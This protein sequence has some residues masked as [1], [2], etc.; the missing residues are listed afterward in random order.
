MFHCVILQ[1]IQNK[2][3]SSSPRAVAVNFAFAHD[4]CQYC[5]HLSQR[6]ASES[7]E[8]SACRSKFALTHSEKT[9]AFVKG[10]VLPSATK[11]LELLGDFTS[12]GKLGTRLRPVRRLSQGCV[13]K[14]NQK[15]MKANT[16]TCCIQGTH[17]RHGGKRLFNAVTSKIIKGSS[18][19]NVRRQATTC[20]YS[21]Y[22]LGAIQQLR[23]TISLELSMLIP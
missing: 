2:E 8:A 20:G 10:G 1:Q 4:N 17:D 12:Q 18:A 5:R 21:G 6:V 16:S 14:V 13:T 7:L 15:R 19:P 23:V 3:K 11:H 9:S 22:I